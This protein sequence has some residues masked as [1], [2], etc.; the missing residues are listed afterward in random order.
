MRYEDML[1]HP[2]EVFGEL[3]RWLQLPQDPAR[4]RK[5]VEL[6]SFDQLK[7]QERA[8]GF[9]EKPKSAD[10]FFREGKAGQWRSQ[11]TRNQIRRIMSDHSEQMRRFGYFE[12]AQRFLDQ[13]QRPLAP[14]MKQPQR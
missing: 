10:V 5:A 4:L 2:L 7:Q 8:K 6:S 12:E 1:E 14:L 3:T 9:K 11:L 13:A